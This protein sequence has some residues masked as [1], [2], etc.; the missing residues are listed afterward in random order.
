MAF[1]MSEEMVRVGKMADM[2]ACRGHAVVMQPEDGP[3]FW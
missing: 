1:L 2:D 3:S